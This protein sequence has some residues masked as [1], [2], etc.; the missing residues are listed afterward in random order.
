EQVRIASVQWSPIREAGERT[1]V[2]D[3][4]LEEVQSLFRLEM[5]THLPGALK[6]LERAVV[7]AQVA[8][9]EARREGE[10]PGTVAAK[11]NRV[12]A[13]GGQVVE[14][15]RVAAASGLINLAGPIREAVQVAAQQSQDVLRP[16]ATIPAPPAAVGT[17]PQTT[18]STSGPA[19]SQSTTVSTSPPPPPPP[20]SEPPPPPTTTPPTTTIPPT[21]TSPPPSSS[22]QAP[23]S[24]ADP[25]RDTG[26]LGN[27]GDQTPAGVE[28]A[29]PTTTP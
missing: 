12:Q 1:R 6:A 17:P 2:A 16:P 8:V 21:T 18:E 14:Q 7:A 29:P 19:P 15:V 27:A 23:E 24:P 5:F 25:G 9:A 11:L 28:G 3:E 10:L 13:G 20:T 4:R 26:D 22:E